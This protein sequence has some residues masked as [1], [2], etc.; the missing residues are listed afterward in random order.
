M[1][2]AVR[3]T[4]RES[5]TVLT[6]TAV[7]PRVC[8]FLFGFIVLRGVMAGDAYDHREEKVEA[9]WLTVTRAAIETVAVMGETDGAA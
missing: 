5:T 9:Q 4:F 1:R 7:L 8:L 3:I 6:G 2:T